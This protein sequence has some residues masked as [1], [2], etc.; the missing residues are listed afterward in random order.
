MIEYALIDLFR[1]DS[2]DKQLDISFDDVHITNSDFRGQDFELTESLCSESELRFGCCEAS[3]LKLK[4]NNKFGELKGKKLN[5]KM[6]L[7]GNVDLPFQFGTYRVEEDTVSGDK[8]YRDITAYDD[9]YYII[10]KDVAHWYNALEFPLTQKEFRY[11]FFDFLEI[12]Q[13]ETTLIMDDMLIEQTINSTEISG[14]DVI[15]SLCEINGVF[16]HI[17]RKGKFEYISLSSTVRIYPDSILY[18]SSKLLPLSGQ[19]TETRESLTYSMYTSCEYEDFET[20]AISKLQIRQEQDDIGTIVG[21]GNNAYIIED[22]FLLYGKNPDDLHEIATKLLSKI[23]DIIYRPASISLRGNPCLEV[24]DG[25]V[26]HTRSKEVITYILQRTIKGIQGIT[27]DFVSEGVY[28]YSEQVNSTQ[29]TINQLRGKTN[30]LERDVERTMSRVSDVEKELSTTVTQTI[31]GLKID[32]E[33]AIKD[34]SNMT[35]SL[36]ET[37]DKVQKSTYEF[38]TEELKISKDGSEMTTHISEDGMTVKKGGSDVLIAD[39]K[40]V[41]AYD[42]HAKSYLIIGKNSRLEDYGNG[43]RTGCFWIGS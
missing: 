24:G 5:V 22:N 32:I 40:G 34:V 3:S 38:N 27:D 20:S 2:I 23:C 16:G 11:S 17:N 15:T 28:E 7:E 14:K 1:Q 42:L 8:Q 33:K 25:I 21:D 26:C 43:K 29:R 18:P 4:V 31:E 41:S 35:E 9:M 19:Y 30:V 10:N 37:S 36:D 13:V 6:I 39:N 12:E